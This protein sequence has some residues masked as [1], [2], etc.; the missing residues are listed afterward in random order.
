MLRQ[1]STFSNFV[2]L[3]FL[4]GISSLS[5]A[6]KD[7]VH[8]KNGMVV[9]ASEIASQ[10]GVEILKQG[11]NAVDAAVAV[12]FTLAVT[13][14]SAGNL[15][16]G[17]FM[18]ISL[19]D[20]TS[21]TIDF[22]ETAPYK[23]HANIYLDING[24]LIEDNSLRGW[25]S[26]G[27][28]GSVA[29]MLYVLEKYGSMKLT[30]LI[31]PAIELASNGFLL[32][33]RLSELMKESFELFSKYESSR[34]IFTNNGSPWQEG[35]LLVQKDLA[36][37]LKLIRD[38]GFDGFY[39]GKIADLLVEQS[40]EN[41]GYFSL[42]DLK[43]YQP[44][45]RKPILGN[46]KGHKIITMPPPSAGG[47]N[48]VQILNVLEKAEISKDMWGSSKYIHL[49]TEIF[50]RIFADR[51]K[52]F[53]DSDFYP[54]PIDWLLS[55]DYAENLFH[56]ISSKAL[57]ANE[58]APSS[59]II[60]ES[61]ETTHYCV[62]DKDGNAV[63]TT[64]TLNSPFGN[65]IVVEGAGFLMNNEMD[66]FSSQPGKP[67]VYGL[68]GSEANSIQPYKR[69]L[70][71]M[72]PTIILKDNHPYLI[73]GARGGSMIMTSVLQ[74]IVNCIDFEMN[75]SEAI[76][77]PRIHH[78]WL[79][80]KLTFENLGIVNDVRE[81]LIKRGHIFGET[82]VIGRVEGILIDNEN[83]IIWGASDSRGFGKAIGY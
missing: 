7:P 69:M 6:S 83:K 43:N 67:N 24:N 42:E 33:Y 50:K 54:V 13:H 29:G 22:R 82:D 80:D 71:S 15:G 19:N 44:I 59:S 8:A 4:I 27:V 38:K 63:S 68:I 55:D 39:R 52:Y 53:G 17:G 34:K 56:N 12:G 48:I 28:P 64:V 20:G 73:V 65:R 76:D 9:S 74:V 1:I 23:T 14:P 18:V 77:A 36:E 58:I 25:T 75:I 57:P 40:K 81:N 35:D 32:D 60:G 61:K 16:G 37:T 70:S 11:G 79:P 51:S 3:L 62:I 66:D 26:S 78:Q 72:S 31:T 10:V 45:E 46:Y 21:T 49:L 41:G 5:A 30:D 47:I 2:I